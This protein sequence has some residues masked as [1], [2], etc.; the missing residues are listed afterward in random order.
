MQAMAVSDRK[1]HKVS[2]GTNSAHRKQQLKH[3]WTNQAE[4]PLVS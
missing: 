1:G 4:A 2:K 3:L